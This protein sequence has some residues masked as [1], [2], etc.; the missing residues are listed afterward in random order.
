MSIKKVEGM[1]K[2]RTHEVACLA[3]ANR[4]GVN[5]LGTLLVGDDIQ[6][7][8]EVHCSGLGADIK[9][10]MLYGNEDS[11]DQ[12]DAYTKAEPTIYDFPEIWLSQLSRIIE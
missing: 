12:I 7:L 11:P 2:A 9:A 6:W 5:R 1:R 8:R 4:S 10:V 3:M